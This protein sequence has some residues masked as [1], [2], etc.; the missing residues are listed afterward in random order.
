MSDNIFFD[1][2]DLK[3]C[4]ENV[5]IGKTVRIRRPELVSIDDGTIID[6]FTYISGEV[7]IGQYVHIGS[8]CTLQGSESK[9]SIGNFVGIASGVRIF[10]CSSD[11]IDSSMEL[12]S[13]PKDQRFGGTKAKISIDNFCIIGANSVVLP[14]AKIP[15]GFSAG[16]NSKLTRHLN[17]REWHF[18]TD[19]QAGTLIR[20]LNSKKLIEAAKRINGISS[21][22]ELNDK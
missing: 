2:N 16:V 13:I 15:Q 14:G 7:E 22:I 12:P 18:L 5:I 1:L 10:A 4:G 19:D 3:Y 8:C 20:R 6:D 9:I 17:Y 21:N 11:F